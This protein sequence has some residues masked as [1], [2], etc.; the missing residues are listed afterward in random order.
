MTANKQRILTL[1]S[2]V[3]AL[4]AQDIKTKLPDM[5]PSIIYR[6]LE[7]F[8][9][10][11]ILRTV[12]VDSGRTYYEPATC[13]SHAHFVCDGCHAVAPLRDEVEVPKRA[14][15]SGVRVTHTDIVVHGTC[16][17]CFA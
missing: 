11:G 16:P 14:L 9:E 12:T 17:A 6:N 10:D 1:F 2:S 5:D 15:P 7:R 8:V 13:I 4:S 3:H